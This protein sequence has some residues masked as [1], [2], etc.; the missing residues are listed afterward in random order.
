MV[1]T[2][3]PRAVYCTFV[4]KHTVHETLSCSTQV[5]E[6]WLHKSQDH[7]RSWTDAAECWRRI[8]QKTL[9]AP[10]SLPFPQSLFPRS[11]SY[12]L[13]YILPGSGETS[14]CTSFYLV[15]PGLDQTSH[16]VWID[17]RPANLDPL[18]CSRARA[19]PAIEDKQT[20]VHHHGLLQSQLLLSP[21]V[22]G[23]ALG[24]G[25]WVN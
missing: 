10:L 20:G 6:R 14:L 1:A 15:S 23:W 4:K 24:I 21:W 13:G 22:Q 8:S 11:K 12:C 16:G 25:V 17:F 18:P 9:Q 19:K 3:I 2:R 7:I 5:W